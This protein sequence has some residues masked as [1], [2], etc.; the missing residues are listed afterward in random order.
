M[1]NNIIGQTFN[2]YD[3]DYTIHRIV[4][5]GQQVEA[6]SPDGTLRTFPMITAL[7][8]LNLITYHGN[9]VWK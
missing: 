9:G 3:V 5:S 1:S 4:D 7:V 2:F 6:T 8:G